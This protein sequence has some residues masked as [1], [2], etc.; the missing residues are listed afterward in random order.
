MERGGMSQR[1]HPVEDEG[2]EVFVSI[3]RACGGL[4][5]FA[6]QFALQLVGLDP[7]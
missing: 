5:L 7:V 1:P 3:H 4:L 2:G 6:L